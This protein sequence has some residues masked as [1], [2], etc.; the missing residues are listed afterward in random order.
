MVWHINARSAAT[1]GARSATRSG[2]PKRAVNDDGPAHVMNPVWIAI[3][4][5]AIVAMA[6]GLRRLMSSRSGETS[7]V[8]LGSISEGWLAE[9]KG[10]R[11]DRFDS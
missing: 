10:I 4:L 2:P 11:K 3:S 9:Q 8:D 7:E 1:A 5:V 6:L